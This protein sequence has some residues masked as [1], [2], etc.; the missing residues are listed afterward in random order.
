VNH[1]INYRLLLVA[2]CAG[3]LFTLAARERI[4]TSSGGIPRN[5][6]NLCFSALSLVCALGLQQIDADLIR[7]AEADLDLSSLRPATAG[8]A[9][10]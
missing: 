6:N 3:P 2:G 9:A 7:E 10:G 4:A 5:I 8:T 1:Y